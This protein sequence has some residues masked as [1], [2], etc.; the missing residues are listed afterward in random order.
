MKKVLI[1]EDE[2]LVYNEIKNELGSDFEPVRVSNYAAAKGR[3]D[4]ENGLFDCVVLDLHINPLGLGLKDIDKY[5]PCYGMAV[6]AAFTEGKSEEEKAKIQK[7]TII[8][9][10][11][12]R[13]LNSRDFD[14]KNVEIIPKKEDSITNVVNLIKRICSIA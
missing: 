10:G 9:S 6:L 11:F 14:R 13:E 7:K 8:Y 3:W 1:V 5:S 2:G 4:R 12:T